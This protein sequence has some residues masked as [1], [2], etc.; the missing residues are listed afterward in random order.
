MW[1]PNGKQWAV[2][3]ATLALSLTL[4]LSTAPRLVPVPPQAGD[5]VT[6]LMSQDASRPND[7]FRKYLAPASRSEARM[8]T[9]PVF[10]NRLAL[11]V[12]LLG[13]AGCWFFARPWRRNSN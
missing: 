13:V 5:D 8:K 3:W 1:E 4:W 7:P 11:A 9:N 6:A 10:V 2:I 12:V